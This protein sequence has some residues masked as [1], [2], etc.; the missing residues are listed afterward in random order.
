MNECSSKPCQNNGTCI[1][2]INRFE[3]QCVPGYTGTQCEV[4]NIILSINNSKFKET[5]QY[6]IYWYL[7]KVHRVTCQ[8]G[9]ISFCVFGRYHSTLVHV[10][11]YRPTMNF[12]IVKYWFIVITNIKWSSRQIIFWFFF[13]CCY[14]YTLKW[15]KI[16]IE[17]VQY[18]WL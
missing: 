9:L 10:T 4:G 11:K 1:D 17:S 16:D 13:Y 5:K 8:L 2:L 18:P 7:Q 6:S 3:C 12:V 15:R 14:C